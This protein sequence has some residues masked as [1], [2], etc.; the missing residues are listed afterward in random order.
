MFVGLTGG[1][2]SGKS[3]V[4]KMF[5]A[6]GARIVYAD[7]ISRELL[8]IGS[9]GYAPVLSRFG[10][11]VQL[12]DGQIDRQ[13]LAQEVFSNAEALRDLETIVHP[14]V[15]QE[16]AKIR[17]EV[18]STDIVI[19][20]S[21]LLIEKEIHLTCDSVIVVIADEQVRIERLMARGLDRSEV[22]SRMDNQLDDSIRVA[23]AD[24]VIENSGSL[25]DL[26]AQVQAVWSTLTT[27]RQT[28]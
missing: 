9:P 18:S 7:V 13:A 24:Y 23:V 25:T 10:T 11:K 8:D 17:S 14:L 5:E 12:P 15:A 4:A 26:S 21:P 2:G 20:E 22:L 28:L 19:Y 3:T 16:V 27:A 6:L 1:I